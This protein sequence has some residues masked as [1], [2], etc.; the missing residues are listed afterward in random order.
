M[1]AGRGGIRWR[2]QHAL[3]YAAVALFSACLAGYSYL[4]MLE[5][6]VTKTVSFAAA[7]TAVV[8]R[9]ESRDEGAETDASAVTAA[10]AGWHTPSNPP[11][12]D[13]EGCQTVVFFHVPKTGG[14]SVNGLWNGAGRDRV[15]GW[16]GG[17]TLKSLR[18]TKLEAAKQ[19]DVLRNM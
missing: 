17:Y 8:P 7:G 5:G 18:V 12:W 15:L 4:A 9:S 13:Q 14:E 19:E 10:T 6:S 3:T 2:P 1:G 16:E 11:P